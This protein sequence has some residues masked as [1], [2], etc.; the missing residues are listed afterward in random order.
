V[1][2][3]ECFRLVWTPFI[4]KRK[5][6]QY[7]AVGVVCPRVLG[8]GGDLELRVGGRKYTARQSELSRYP[9]EPY[10]YLW[11][12]PR[13][14][15]VTQCKAAW[16]TPFKQIYRDTL[17]LKPAEKCRINVIF[18][19]QA[20]LG[21]Q[22]LDDEL[23]SLDNPEFIEVLL[24]LFDMTAQRKRPRRLIC[25][26]STRLVNHCLDP[27]RV[28]QQNLD[29][30]KHHIL[31]GQLLWGLL[32]FNMHSESCGLEEMCRDIYAARRLSERF[33][34]AIP[35][36]ASVHN[37]P[38]HTATLG[39]VLRSA[40]CKFLQISGNGDAPSPSAGPLFLWCLPDETELLCYHHSGIETP[41]L[42]SSDWP[43][44]DWLSVQVIGKKAESRVSEIIEELDWIESIFDWPVCK[45][46]SLEDYGR[47]VISHSKEN[48]PVIE[49][50][51][52]D[53]WISGITGEARSTG[54]ARLDKY[55]LAGVETLHTLKAL[56][57]GKAVP[58]GI[59]ADIRKAYQELALYSEHTWSP[60]VTD[61][62]NAS[63]K[64]DYYKRPIRASNKSAP[65]ADEKMAGL[66]DKTDLVDSAHKTIDG[67]ES[68]AVV[69]L[70][71]KKVSGDRRTHIVL[72]N[73]L[74]WARSGAVRIRDHGLLKGEFELVD[75]TTGGKVLYE[76][77]NGEI[78]FVSPPVPACG[79]LALQVRP[80]RHRSVPRPLSEWN[81]GNLSLN[82]DSYSLQFHRAGGLVRWYDRV[83]SCQW[84]SHKV[85]F[86]M[87]TYLYEMPGFERI[88]SFASHTLCGIDSDL[89]GRYY[90]R[91]YENMSNFGPVSGNRAQ[92]TGEITP[93]YSR[94]TIK[95]DC[96]TRKPS[97][98]RSGDIRGYQ[99]TFT[100]YRGQSD[101][102]VNMQLSGKR[103]TFAAEA[104]YTFFPFAEEHPIVMID[105]IGH[106]VL[107]G[108]DFADNANAGHMAV[109]RG[110]RVEG[111]HVGI[112]FYPLHTPLV[113]IGS[114][115]AYFYDDNSEYK[116]GIIYATLFSNCWGINYPQC[117]S[118]DYSYDFVMD[119]TG[120]DDWD[121]GMTRQ[122]TE[123]H[124]PLLAK[125]TAGFRGEPTKSLL[126]IEPASIELVNLKPAD[127]ESGIV[128]RL[129]NADV[130]SVVA[131]LK[132]PNL[133]RKDSLWLCDLLERPSRRNI[134][135]DWEGQARITLKPNQIITML[136]Q[137]S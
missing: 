94:V 111:R 10:T 76:R 137:R 36:A 43:W 9:N 123:L 67:L 104:G 132:L 54:L 109:Y 38:A 84:C 106:C 22:A 56:T 60:Q 129:W 107:S 6:R 5:N 13:P 2:L 130:E 25:T 21:Y 79:Y 69:G 91:G 126:S 64:E 101:L 78:E 131:R 37:I 99:T 66:P 82:S 80:V 114:P 116:T 81:Q 7:Q 124:R 3:A 63:G 75:P 89:I 44:P 122:G 51:F 46:S 8:S 35:Q 110:L 97:R 96:P 135:V 117:Q 20:D 92:I 95:A 49:K 14:A 115:G 33:G 57:S 134:K 105:R 113:S 50:E 90:R 48:L 59:R 120:N 32:P 73:C 34:Q 65:S 11:L 47:S 15:R 41:L 30:L 31:S 86:P 12:I 100:C 133:R 16:K 28:S 127:F 23:F 27:K 53:P 29:R 39:M 61:T 98:R 26:F 88:I 108:D 42:P 55:R 112:N 62:H 102:Y 85:E 52:V 87:G 1:S 19:A 118:G 40:G 103:P 4:Q 45:I 24:N 119:P 93:L 71:G 74:S 68:G 125:V 58:E 17:K 128:F 70:A 136:L 83:H 18:K 77:G 121:G 72:Y